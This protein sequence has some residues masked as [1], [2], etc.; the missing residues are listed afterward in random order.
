M[1]KGDEASNF[2][3][4]KYLHVLYIDEFVTVSM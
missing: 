1:A 3:F 2:G 4:R